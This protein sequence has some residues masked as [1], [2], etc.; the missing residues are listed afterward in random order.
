MLSSVALWMDARCGKREP[1]LSDA[2]DRYL[3]WMSV[4]GSMRIFGISDYKNPPPSQT[5]SPIA[6]LQRPGLSDSAT[7][8]SPSPLL[9]DY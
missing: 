9:G 1:V 5:T 2:R 8:S 6:A 3:S 7:V 4:D